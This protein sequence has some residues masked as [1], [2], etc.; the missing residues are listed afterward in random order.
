MFKCMSLFMVGFRSI[1]F[2]WTDNAI[3][4]GK[5]ITTSI[6]SQRPLKVFFQVVP[7][8]EWNE[9]FSHY[10]MCVCICVEQEDY[11]ITGW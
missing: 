5:I 7:K 9:V 8:D 6:N 3:R 4:G 11:F 1:S 10:S 2:K